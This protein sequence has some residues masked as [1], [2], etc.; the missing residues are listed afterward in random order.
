[1]SIAR[2]SRRS[3]C[4]TVSRRRLRPDLE[5][6]SSDPIQLGGT[7]LL[8]FTPEG[9]ATSGSLYVRGRK[10]VQMPYECSVRT[11]RARVHR[12]DERQHAW[13]EHS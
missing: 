7:T 12:Y 5:G 11:G 10:G 3:A 4:P 13:T 1:M 2:S 6:Q 8:T 9:T